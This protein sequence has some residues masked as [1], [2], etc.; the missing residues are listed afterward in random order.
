MRARVRWGGRM[1][2]IFSGV[3][4]ANLH[5]ET[6]GNLRVMCYLMG[7]MSGEPRQG[8]ARLYILLT[9]YDLLTVSQ[10]LVS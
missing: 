4:S 7:L 9:S 5:M 8:D 2:A 10:L 3:F 1:T 6:R